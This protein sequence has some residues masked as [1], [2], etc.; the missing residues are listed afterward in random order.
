MFTNLVGVFTIQPTSQGD[1]PAGAWYEK[2][3]ETFYQHDS[4]SACGTNPLRFCP[5][6]MVQRGYMADLL[7]NGLGL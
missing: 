7:V 4:T 6:Q 5:M 1:V 3:V 2:Y